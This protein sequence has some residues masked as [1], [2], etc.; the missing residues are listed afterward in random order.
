MLTDKIARVAAALGQHV[1]GRPA[2]GGGDTNLTGALGIPTV[3]GLGPRGGGAHA[4]HEHA[5]LSSLGERID[6]VTRL[7]TT[8]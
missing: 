8:L 4:V 1:E 6:L 3:D 7:L 2:A 5:L